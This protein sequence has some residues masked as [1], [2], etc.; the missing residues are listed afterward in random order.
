MTIKHTKTFTDQL[1]VDSTV[2]YFSGF[3]AIKMEYSKD[4]KNVEFYAAALKV[5]N[6]QT[7]ALTGT[8][9][10]IYA[11]STNAVETVTFLNQADIRP[12]Q[13]HSYLVDTRASG[14]TSVEFM[15][16]RT[17]RMTDLSVTNVSIE[18]KTIKYRINSDKRIEVIRTVLSLPSK[19][20][21]TAYYRDANIECMAAN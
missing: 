7:D 3:F 12:D 13:K 15:I 16:P 11:E 5:S 19:L 4:T 1:I 2:N 20:G 18:M 10:I 6:Y 14:G 8:M 21:I 9:I 17:R